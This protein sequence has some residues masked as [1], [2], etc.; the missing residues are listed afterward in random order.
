MFDLLFAA[1]IIGTCIEI[2]KER[3]APTVPAENWANKN[4]YHKDM[5]D[6]VPIEQVMKN[7]QNG[8]YKI[9]E[10]YPEP[11][12]DPV[13]GKII[14]ENCSLYNRDL[15]NYGAAKTMEWVKQGKYNLTPE[16]LK[17]EN[18]RIEKKYEYLRSLL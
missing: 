2:I 11:H 13:S 15:R 16:E 18:E 17:K 6:G 7:V 14:I 10:T 8:R 1:S 9:T 12:K 5:A 3:N 4:L